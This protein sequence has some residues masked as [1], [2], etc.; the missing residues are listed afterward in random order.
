MGK[1]NLRTEII[2]N[3]VG[4]SKCLNTIVVFVCLFVAAFLF[5][6]YVVS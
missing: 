1:H 2:F 5:F 6:V 3:S 4:A